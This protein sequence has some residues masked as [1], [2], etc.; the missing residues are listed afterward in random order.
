MVLRGR[1]KFLGGMALF[2]AGSLIVFLAL[3]GTGSTTSSSAA[4]SKPS[5]ATSAATSGPD[6][7]AL[8]LG[9]SKTTTTN[10]RRGYLYECV[11]MTGGGGA[12]KNGPWIHGSTYDLTQKFV[13]DGAVDWPKAFFKKL[14]KG[15][16]LSLTGNGLPKHTTGVF[17]VQPSDDAAQIDPNP[18]RISAYKLSEKIPGHPKYHSTPGCAQGQVGVMTSGAALF[19]AVD[20][21][22]QDAVAHEVQDSC[23]GHPQ[24]SG[25]YHYHGL[26]ACIATGKANKQSK[27]IGWALDGFPIYGPRGAGGVYLNNDAL[28]EC[29]GIISKVN[30]MGKKR[31]LFHYVANYEFPYTV[32][33]YRGGAVAGGPPG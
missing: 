8:P 30:Y 6:L 24:E 21:K 18:N 20:A 31:K 28:D 25:V 13:V 16:V 12:Q 3:T 22:D 1:I 10:P 15:S 32:G 4:T 26:P 9:D 14:L 23:S 17:P 5:S 29:H 33:C 2:A 11:K 27:L 19:A 7:T